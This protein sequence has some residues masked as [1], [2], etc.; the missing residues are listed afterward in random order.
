MGWLVPYP[1]WWH[2][3]WHVQ[4]AIFII[5]G[6]WYLTPLA[7]QMG[8]TPAHIDK[9]S[10][11]KNFRYTDEF[12]V[13]LTTASV[14]Y[15]NSLFNDAGVQ[16]MP[17]FLQ[18]IRNNENLHD[19]GW[20][21]FNV[22][23]PYTHMRHA[24]RHADWKTFESL[25]PVWLQ[26][27][28]VTSKTRYAA[29]ILS[30]KRTIASVPEEWRAALWELTFGRLNDDGFFTGMDAVLEWINH[31]AKSTMSINTC[32]SRQVRETVTS[33]NVRVPLIRAMES[34]LHLDR[35]GPDSDKRPCNTTADN[36]F[37][38]LQETFGD[39]YTVLMKKKS[40]HSVLFDNVKYW[41]EK[42][43]CPSK[44]RWDCDAAISPSAFFL[45]EMKHFK[46]KIASIAGR[47]CTAYVETVAKED[48]DDN[49]DEDD[50]DEDAY[51]SDDEASDFF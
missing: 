48:D 40:A 1:G 4:K 23:I 34:I 9:N 24:V 35:S 17:R 12:L 51:S 6:N 47:R 44:K 22:L 30:W 33:L 39:R 41:K 28:V 21:T 49:N 3:E 37:S 13:N 27:F 20:F 46:S 15:F 7:Y 2:F 19:I 42:A 29:L 14:R 5:W 8:R 45:G 25:L 18:L 43:D 26:L 32:E 31:L 50:E 10:K 36:I 38:W 16:D 11:A